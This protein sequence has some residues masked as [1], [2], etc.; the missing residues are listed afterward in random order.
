MQPRNCLATIAL[1]STLFCAPA[2]ANDGFGGLSA[3]GL[4]FGQTDA[5]AMIE[6]DLFIGLDQIRVEYLFHNK[7]DRDVT[8]EV[9]FPMPPIPAGSLMMSDWNLPDDLSRDNLVGFTATVDGQPMPTTI[10]RIAVLDQSEGDGAPLSAQY[11]SPGVD[12]TADMRRLGLPLT[13]DTQTIVTALMALTSEQR[14]EVQALGLADYSPTPAAPEEAW[15]NWSIVLRYH[16]T[17]TFPSGA[18]IR[19]AHSYQNLPAGGVFVWKHPPE[20]EWLRDIRDQYCV[21]DA[22]SRGIM[23][24]LSGSAM[25]DGS[26]VGMSWNIAYVLRTANSWAGPIGRFRLTLDKGD[27]RHIVSICADGIKKTGDTTF[28]WEKTDFVP[29]R[30]LDILVVAPMTY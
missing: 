26:A 24:R 11:D 15:P 13:L 9:I 1:L 17:Q 21:D 22:T 7:T 8:G 19:I 28:V 2:H 4:T 23:K 16:W 20:D 29:D 25:D 18:D 14:A 30:D 27:A 3:T 10:D 5:I 12:V 6:E